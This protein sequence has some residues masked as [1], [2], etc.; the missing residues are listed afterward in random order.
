[1]YSTI[2]SLHLVSLNNCIVC[3]VDITFPGGIDY[4]S[5]PESITFPAGITSRPINITLIDDNIFENT[6]NFSIT[7]QTNPVSLPVIIKNG[8]AI[9]DIQNDDGK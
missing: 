4:H 8:M 7:L 3:E 5:V 9:V 1:M 2:T 6:K